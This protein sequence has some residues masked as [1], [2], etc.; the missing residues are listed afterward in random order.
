MFGLVPAYIHH[1]L[2][3]PKQTYYFTFIVFTVEKKKKKKKKKKKEK[4]KSRNFI[5]QK[6]WSEVLQ[7]KN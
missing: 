6:Q 3:Y 1:V 7:K 4:G 2:T 5:V